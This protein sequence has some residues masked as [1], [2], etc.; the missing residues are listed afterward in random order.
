MTTA[1]TAEQEAQVRL[2]G[3]ATIYRD[4]MTFANAQQA[5]IEDKQFGHQAS[6]LLEFSRDWDELERFIR[7]QKGRS[8]PQSKLHYGDFYAALGK[9]LQELRR[10]VKDKYGFVEN[11]LTNNETREQTKFFAGL[12]AREFIQH[13]VAEMMWQKEVKGQ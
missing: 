7:H 10:D 9:Y 11:G 5:V 13:L 4:A 3:D 12:L 6:G 1:L 8:W 2:A